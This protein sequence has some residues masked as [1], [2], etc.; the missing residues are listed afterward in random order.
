MENL[1]VLTP[2]VNFTNILQAAF[3]H[4]DPKSAIKLL[5]LTVFFALLGSAHVK[6]AHRTLVKLTP[7][8][9]IQTNYLKLSKTFQTVLSKDSLS[10]MIVFWLSWPKAVEDKPETPAPKF[11]IRNCGPSHFNTFQFSCVL[12]K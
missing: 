9:W 10:L 5:N 3:M 1:L 2:G 4:A 11:D 7:G 6:A 8:P 12:N